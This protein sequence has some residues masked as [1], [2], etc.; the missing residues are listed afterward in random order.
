MV[1]AK[2][3]DGPKE[4]IWAKVGQPHFRS[5]EGRVCF[6]LVAIFLSVCFTCSTCCYFI[7]WWFL[8]Y[9][10]FGGVKNFFRFAG[11]WI[12][13]S[14]SFT[15]Q[16][17]FK[18]QEWVAHLFSLQFFG[19]CFKL[20]FILTFNSILT[21]VSQI[22]NGM[23]LCRITCCGLEKRYN[24][25]L[26]RHTIDSLHF[27]SLEPGFCRG[28]RR[29]RVFHLL[30]IGMNQSRLLNWSPRGSVNTCGVCWMSFFGTGPG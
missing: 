21:N 24:C 27:L 20:T 14:R 11:N 22:L 17:R 5:N 8:V 23:S 25:H 3:L 7:F 30:P 2:W 15:I 18:C 16:A 19:S 4:K 26:L 29:V 1:R 28:T 10:E 6:L 13:H 12:F 9:T